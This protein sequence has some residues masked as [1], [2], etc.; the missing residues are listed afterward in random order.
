MRATMMFCIWMLLP[1]QVFA[2][3]H[4]VSEHDGRQSFPE[5]FP[6]DGRAIRVGDNLGDESKFRWLVAELHVPAKIGDE[7]TE[8]RTVGLQIA[9][10]DGGEVYVDGELEGRFDND[11]PLLAIVAN[12]AR[13]G[14]LVNVAIQSFGKVQGGDKFDEATF[15]LLPADRSAPVSL[16][17][18]VG[19]KIGDVPDGLI[20]LSQGGGMSDYQDATAEKLRAGGFKWFRTDNVLTSALKRNDRGEFVYD[21]KELDQRLDFI[22]KVGAAPILAASY[23]PQVLD[24]VP[25]NNRQSAPS[26]YT[27]WEELCFQAAKHSLERG[28]RVP[29]WEVWNEANSGWIKPG[30]RDTGGDEFTQL[31]RKAIGVDAPDHEIVRRFEAYAKLYRATAHGVLR[32]DS[33][34]KIGG[35]ASASGPFENSECGS[36]Q[37]G[38]GFARGLMLW[39]VRERLPLDFISWH[40]YFQSAEEIARQADALRS[41]LEEFPQLERSVRDLM[42]TEWNEAWWPDRPHDHEIGAAWCADGMIRTMIPKR[43]KPCLFYVKQ[44]DMTFRG[45]W[46]ILMQDNRPKPSY[47][48]ARIF[49][50]LRGD[51]IGVKGASDDVCAVAAFDP[52]S[53]RLAII[54][55]NFRFR[56][57]HR[58]QVALTIDRLPAALANGAWREWTIDSQHSNVFH[59]A[60]RCELE[61]TQSGRIQDGKF[62]YERN[63]PANSVVMLEIEAGEE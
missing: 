48:A 43:I 4:I 3:W 60:N 63:I 7:S 39:C 11:H 15:V 50:S 20:G 14:Q 2:Q 6:T 56:Y 18:N 1:T 29:Y 25:D 51:W 30:P 52:G 41:Y 36:C 21:W 38:K 27:A 13:P 26:D 10:G 46:S 35:P 44:G 5:A 8:G 54:L 45:D 37:H 31:Y 57:A 33:A 12:N 62:A 22:H 32:A 17:V 34:A 19:E 59:D 16:T 55:V 40:E 42:I 23:M 47:N 58:R 24:A 53:R 61:M 49:N 28:K 9:C